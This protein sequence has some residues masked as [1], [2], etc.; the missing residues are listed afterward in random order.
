MPRKPGDDFSDFAKVERDL[1]FLLGCFVEVLTEMGETALA[2]R[3]PWQHADSDDPLPPRAAQA[4]SVAFQLLNHAEENAAAQQRRLDETA[5]GFTH[6]P[7]LWGHTLR[8]LAELGVGAEQIA[9]ALP[10]LRVE[11]VLTAHPTEAKRA[12]VLE[13]HRELYLL[14]V[15][16]ENRMWTP[17]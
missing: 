8:Q 1:A 4:Y 13:H 7:G 6:E 17:S 3:L 12:T 14:Q 11:P 2:A 10:D 5:H 9:A 15:K 16:N